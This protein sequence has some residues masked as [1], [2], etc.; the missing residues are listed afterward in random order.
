MGSKPTTQTKPQSINV[1]QNE[2]RKSESNAG[3]AGHKNNGTNQPGY[4]QHGGNQQGNNQLGYNQQGN[5]QYGGNQQGNNQ[6]GNNQQG[7]NQQDQVT[8]GNDQ[9]NYHSGNQQGNNQLDNTQ[10]GINQLGNNQQGS[11]QQDHRPP[12]NDPQDNHGGNQQGNNQLDNNQQ[13]NNQ[14]GNNQQGIQQQDHR[15]PGNDQQDHHQKG[16]QEQGRQDEITRQKQRESPQLSPPV[17]LNREPESKPEPERKPEPEPEAK[18][19]PEPKPE[20]ERK[21][22]PE[23]EPEKKAS[24]SEY[25][26]TL[27]PEPKPEPEQQHKPKSAPKTK[28]E[29]VQKT[30]PNHVVLS[31]QE[32]RKE[33]FDG[34]EESEQGGYVC[35]IEFR[36]S[37][38]DIDRVYE[39]YPNTSAGPFVDLEFTLDDAIENQTEVLEWKRPMEF[40]RAPVLFSP[41]ATRCDLGHDF[42][43]THWFLSMLA[44]LSEKPELFYK[45]VPEDGWIPEDGVFRCRFWRFGEWKDVHIDDYLPVINGYILRG[46]KSQSN[47]NEM[48]PSLVE[49]AFA[50]FH[51]NYS[52]IYV[53]PGDAFL[54]LTGG[55]SEYIY[56]TK[57]LQE[58]SSGSMEKAL[59]LLQR[60]KNALRTGSLLLC[61]VHEDYASHKGLVGSHAYSLTGSEEVT[62]KGGKKV[63]LVR[64]WNPWGHTEWKGRWSDGAPEWD[65]VPPDSVQPIST[66]N[67]EFWMQLDDFIKYFTRL[68]I[69]SISPD[70][71]RD[72]SEDILKYKTCIY[73]D[74]FGETAAGF[75]NKIKNPKYLFTVPE[76]GKD[77]TGK[78]PLVLQIIQKTMIRNADEKFSIR[79]D[80]YR[81]LG[82]NENST[83]LVTEELGE[84][85]H[86]YKM[87]LQM[88]NRFCVE[89]GRYMA[90]PST[91]NAGEKK[92]FL[93]RIFSS[94]PL[95]YVKDTPIRAIVMACDIDRDA[96]LNLDTEICFCECYFG[97]WVHKIN[98]GGQISHPTH[99]LNPQY[100]FTIPADGGEELVSF[101]LTQAPRSTRDPIGFRV[102]PLEGAVPVNQDYLY[103]NYENCPANTEGSQG[104]FVNANC[105]TSIWRLPPGRYLLLIH[106]NATTDQNIYAL[107]CRA[108]CN[109]NID[110][111]GSTGIVSLSRQ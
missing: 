31:R 56:F 23:P 28:L 11:N 85:N 24:E 104:T 59:S 71:N 38:E 47:E 21:P 54:A 4:S 7:S 55:V 32:N 93:I 48:W 42:G 45:V 82:E 37:V 44:V 86:I 79:I 60:V 9:Q 3:N 46:A 99:Y 53:Q 15:P 5:N 14:L 58:D 98:A 87:E 36:H 62:R 10:Q 88:T 83:I 92:E 80:L 2:L 106:M 65:T 27:K 57:D 73:G 35:F 52:T 26:P 103:N 6:I 30:E 78:V 61:E 96:E 19:E 49:K 13:G 22:E 72:G 110:M 81:V 89:P 29:Q 64:I 101:T 63:Q 74:W 34:Y 108:S 91:M 41:G 109:L 40:A 12:G 76:D 70:F 25:K 17:Y 66:A 102:Y 8:P 16:N 43:Y 67:G 39:Q 51:G 90:V 95:S 33:I 107:V 100:G 69:C 111:I 97:R 18:P 77:E 94:G 84:E 68:I 50:R 105:I 75:Q 20:P 1:G